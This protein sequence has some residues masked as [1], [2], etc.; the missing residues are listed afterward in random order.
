MQHRSDKYAIRMAD[1]GKWHPQT[2]GEGVFGTVVGVLAPG[3]IAQPAGRAMNSSRTVGLG[4]EQRRRPLS[5][6][7]AIEAEAALPAGDRRADRDQRIRL[8]LPGRN[9]AVGI[10]LTQPK[11]RENDALRC[12]RGN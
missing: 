6:S 8:P 10:A 11:R 12:C 7:V 1:P 4:S 5:E 9:E 3:N 2:P